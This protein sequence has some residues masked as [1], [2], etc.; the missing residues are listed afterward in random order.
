MCIALKIAKIE[1]AGLSMVAKIPLAPVCAVGSGVVLPI[2]AALRSDAIRSL[3]T[4]Q[5]WVKVEVRV[6]GRNGQAVKR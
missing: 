4:W 1:V 3:P 6:G 2:R 5:R